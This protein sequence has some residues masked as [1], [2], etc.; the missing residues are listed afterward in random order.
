MP[1]IGGLGKIPESAERNLHHARAAV[2][3]EEE[4]KKSR[5]TNTFYD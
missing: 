1:G 2:V 5:R 3:E 4:A